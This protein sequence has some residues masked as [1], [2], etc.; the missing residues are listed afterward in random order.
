MFAGRKFS[1]IIF[2][3]WQSQKLRIFRNLCSQWAEFT[4]HMGKLHG[5]LIMKLFIE[6]VKISKLDV[7]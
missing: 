1:G 2:R 5:R 7:N 4:Y 6:Q 3:D